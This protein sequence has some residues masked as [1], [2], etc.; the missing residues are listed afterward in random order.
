MSHPVGMCTDLGPHGIQ[1]NGIGPGY[2][3]PGHAPAG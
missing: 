2:G 1:V 3:F